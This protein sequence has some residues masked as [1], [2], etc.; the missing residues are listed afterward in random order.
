M[1]QSSDHGKR[2]E[3]GLNEEEMSVRFCGSQPKMHNMTINK[4][5]TITLPNLKWA[6]PSHS[7]SPMVILDPSTFQLRK[8]RVS[9]LMCFQDRK[10]SEKKS[11]MS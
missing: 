11:K 4:L 3:G 5:G 6:T 1:D 9:S 10:K 7:L 2:M 8:G